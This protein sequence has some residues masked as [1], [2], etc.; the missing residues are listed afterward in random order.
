MRGLF[1]CTAG[2]ASRAGIT[3][4]FASVHVRPVGPT[5]TTRHW[6]AREF[7]ELPVLVSP[8]QST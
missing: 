1:E 8:Q 3:T 5:R 4:D 7:P 6:C 2:P